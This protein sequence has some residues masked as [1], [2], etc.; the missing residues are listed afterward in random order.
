MIVNGVHCA[1]KYFMRGGLVGRVVRT[2]YV[3]KG[4][5]FRCIT[6]AFHLRSHGVACPEVLAVL[7]RKV[8]PGVYRGVIVSEWVDGSYTL[9][10]AV[11][12]EDATGVLA[13]AASVVRRMHDAGVW[14]ADL[15]AGNILV[16]DGTVFIID[17][18][19]CRVWEDS[20]PPRRR[21]RNI[22]RLARSLEKEGMPFDETVWRR[23]LH[24]Y[25]AGD[26]FLEDLIGEWLVTMRKH[27]ERYR[28]IWRLGL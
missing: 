16:K 12:G 27:V 13:T 8:A 25:A 22:A 6:V 23:F 18:D 7:S 24:A 19:G 4:R 11:R 17:L 9:S 5:F 20:L 21:V 2:L 26:T 10:E 1:V 14:H 28:M 15:N 3:G